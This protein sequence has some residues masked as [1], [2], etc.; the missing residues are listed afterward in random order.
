MADF[1]YVPN[2]VHSPAA[3]PNIEVTQ[4]KSFKQTVYKYDNNFTRKHELYFGDVS[5][6]TRNNLRDHFEG[7]YGPYNSFSWTN[8]PSYVSDSALTVRYDEEAEGK[9]YYEETPPVG[10][11]V[12]NVTLFFVRVVS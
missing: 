9:G 4:G 5:L 11:N 7:Q 10:G 12:F 1:S 8:P 6:T 3:I 2:Y